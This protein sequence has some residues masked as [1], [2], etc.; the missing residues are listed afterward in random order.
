MLK[1]RYQTKAIFVGDVQIGGQNKVVIQSMTTTKTHD[2]E[3]TIQQI[4]NL[5]LAGC[6]LVRVAV[7]DDKDRDAL[8]EL[9]QKSPCPLIADIHFNHHYA[10]AAIK[11]G[12]KK[13]RL[14]PGNISDPEKIKEVIELAKKHNTVIRVGV[15]SGSIPMKILNQYGRSA[16][17]LVEAAKY[18]VQILENLDFYNI[19]ISLKA[20][21]PLMMIAANELAAQTFDYPLHLGVTESGVGEDGII[22][23]TIGLTPVLLHGIG[24]TIRV[25]L[26]GD[27]INEAYVAKK[28]LNVLG[29]QNDLVDIISC[30]T[31]GRL[32][33]DMFKV[34]DEIK[35]FTKNLN[36]PLTIS[37][38]G[39]VVNGIGEGQ[40]ADI[41]IAGSTKKGILFK[42]GKILKT[43][44]ENEI[45][46]E[47]KKLILEQYEAFQQ[48]QTK[49]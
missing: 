41:G 7:L 46:P 12:F 49:K 44:N 37:I 24:D 6:D 27:P 15:N 40:H 16:I 32:D 20:S 9:I 38:L 33:Y 35:Q 21:D 36:F 10:I 19:V 42:K 30:P 45:I 4:T 28:I 34:V 31:C 17:A 39:C 26:T 22:K 43:V 11:A 23:S 18:Y 13:I 5:K 14:N 1:K 3:A 8:P 48:E 47:L 29:L 2:I 25:S